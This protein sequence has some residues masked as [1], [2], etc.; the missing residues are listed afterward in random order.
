MCH[1]EDSAHNCIKAIVDFENLS[2]QREPQSTD[3]LDLYS[4]ICLIWF[5]IKNVPI[6]QFVIQ[7]NKK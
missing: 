7:Y 3:N 6:R 4:L 1:F 5:K 2:Q